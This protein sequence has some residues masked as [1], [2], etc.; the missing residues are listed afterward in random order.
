[1]FNFIVILKIIFLFKFNSI[2]IFNLI[3]NSNVHSHFNLHLTFYTIYNIHTNK[4]TM[5]LK[6]KT[7]CIIGMKVYGSIIGQKRIHSKIEIWVQHSK[8]S[9]LWQSWH[10]TKSQFS[11]SPLAS[12]AINMHLQNVTSA[13]YC[14]E[15]NEEKKGF[16]HRQGQY[17]HN[18][19]HS[20]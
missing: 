15:L 2:L 4:V 1:M 16:T 11:G 8:V 14:V 3:S 19:Y 7:R 20:Y 18:H 10:Q 17:H 9:V 12:A 6:N 5:Y 13:L